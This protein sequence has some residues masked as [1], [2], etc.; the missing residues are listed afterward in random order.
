MLL[1]GPHFMSSRSW[2]RAETI[3]PA[4]KRIMSFCH[5]PG[6]RSSYGLA[7]T[8]SVQSGDINFC[9]TSSSLL[10]VR[11]QASPRLTVAESARS[12]S[13]GDGYLPSALF[14]A[15]KTSTPPSWQK[16]WDC[17]FHQRKHSPAPPREPL[18][19]VSPSLELG[20]H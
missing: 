4:Q 6:P 16:A 15:R 10:H 11:T 18:A 3:S 9:D 13:E 5:F 14:S 12:L 2:F 8:S 7:V 17:S 1:A 20:S 19:V